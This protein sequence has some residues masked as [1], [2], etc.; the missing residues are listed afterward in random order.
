MALGRQGER[1]AELMVGWAELPR[2]PGH[3]F[4][5]RLQAVLIEAGFDGFAEQQCAPV[6]AARQGRPSLPPGRYFRM[7]LVGYFEGIDSERGLEW[8]CADSLSLREF[9]RLGTTEPV[10]DHSWLSKTRARLPLEVHATIFTWVLQRLAEHGLVK[11]D[12]IGVDASTMEA[13]AALRAIVRRET[14][15]GYREMLK[16][17]AAESGIETPTADDLI[18]LDRKRQGKRLSNDEWTSPTDREA[19][20]AKMKDGRTRLA[21]KPEHAVDLDTGAI[22]AA[23]IHPADQGDT[24]TLPATLEAAET[25]LAAV[26]AAP[27]PEDPA[28]LV[29]DKG[30]HSRNGLK[31]LEDGA[32]KS[33]IAEKKVP[34]VSRWHGDEAAQRAV[35]NNRARLRSGVAKEAFKL[36]AELVERSFALTLDRGGMRRAWL[37]GCENL[38]KRYLVHVAGYNLGLLMRLL[39]GA[40]TPR[41]F[42][43]PASGHLLLLATA[44]DAVTAILMV[45]AGSQIAALAVSFQPQ[46]HR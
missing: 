22:V 32:W 37:R 9:L 18:R 35:Y 23:H 4:Y 42:L 29:A 45:A 36:R 39:V 44:D 38:H 27:R 10:P 16:R 3:A 21:Y 14:G 6:Y 30:Y 26:D 24:T 28:E 41:E 1:Q 5:D 13:N 34:G 2:S 17:L 8:R 19:K 33:R 25:N 15:E 40:G 20:I 7:H 11:G 31:D 46:P 12:R 43:A